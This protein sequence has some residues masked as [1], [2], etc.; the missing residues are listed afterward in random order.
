MTSEELGHRSRLSAL[1]VRLPAVDL[2][3]APPAGF[4]MDDDHARCTEKVV[5]VLVPVDSADGDVGGHCPSCQEMVDLAMMDLVR[6]DVV[7]MDHGLH[8]LHVHALDLYTYDDLCQ[9][10]ATPDLDLVLKISCTGDHLFPTTLCGCTE[11][12]LLVMRRTQV[13]DLDHR[14]WCDLGPAG[15]D[16]L[17]RTRK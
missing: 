9:A 17:L 5:L 13:P 7:V 14:T 6:V 11:T 1:V 4:R 3:A 8:C 16:F 10:A 15:S 12:A 2:V